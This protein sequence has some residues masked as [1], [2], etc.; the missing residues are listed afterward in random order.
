MEFFIKQGAT[1]PILKM[2][3]VIDGRSDSYKNIIEILDNA[4]IRF[5]MRREDN[6]IQKIFMNQA[7]IVEKLKNNPDNPTE[8]Y[9]YYKWNANDT[10]KKGRYYGEFSIVLE[11]GELISPIR[12]NLYINII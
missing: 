12:E 4:I 9:I 11:S 5:S 10:N 1:L 2:E 3:P 8:Y 7:Y 6:G